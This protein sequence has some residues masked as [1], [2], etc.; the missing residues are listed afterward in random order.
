MRKVPDSSEA[1]SAFIAHKVEIDSIPIQYLQRLRDLSV[2][3]SIK[4]NTRLDQ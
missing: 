3:P 4:A 2:P 1:L